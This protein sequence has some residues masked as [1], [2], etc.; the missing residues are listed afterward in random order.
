MSKKKKSGKQD[1]TVE[2]IVLIT[3]VLHLAKALIEL[4]E[5]LAG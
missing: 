5:K 1:H 3:A 2:V 4:I